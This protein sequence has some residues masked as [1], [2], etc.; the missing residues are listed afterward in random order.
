MVLFTSETSSSSTSS[1]YV[2]KTYSPDGASTDAPYWLYCPPRSPS[3]RHDWPSPDTHTRPVWSSMSSSPSVEPTATYSFAVA[4][5]SLTRALSNDASLAVVS[6]HVL[7]S[8]EKTVNPS[9]GSSSLAAQPT[10]A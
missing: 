8:G 5:T 9:D 3:E 1:S 7:P 10:A 2:L 6:V 4:C